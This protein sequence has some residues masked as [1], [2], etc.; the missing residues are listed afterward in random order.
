MLVVVKEN[1]DT[2]A[3]LQ[4]LDEFSTKRI[5]HSLALTICLNKVFLFTTGSDKIT[6]V[7]NYFDLW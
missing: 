7:L 4:S 5:L 2:I 1:D 3:A 6:L